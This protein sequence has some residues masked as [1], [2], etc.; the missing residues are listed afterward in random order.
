M[1]KK[2]LCL[3]FVLPLVFASIF[4]LSSC[5]CS[6]ER[7]SSITLS[8]SGQDVTP[9]GKNT[10]TVLKRN[11]P[12][13]VEVKIVPDKYTAEDL[14]WKC[15]PSNVA[16]I[17]SR[18]ALSAKSEGWADVSAQYKNSNGELVYY[19]IKVYVSETKLPSFSSSDVDLTYEGM[20]LLESESATK[21]VPNNM[22]DN[23]ECKYYEISTI[24][25]K[26]TVVETTEI[27]NAGE[28]VVECTRRST[29]TLICSLNVHVL[30]A[31]IPT[32]IDV[33]NVTSVY[34]DESFDKVFAN[35]DEV[36][37]ENGTLLFG[38][39]A[40]SDREIG[41][42]VFVTKATLTSG[43]G[44]YA[45]E[46]QVK[47]STEQDEKNYKFVYT[48]GT[49]TITPRKLAVKVL[50]KTI[51][52]GEE[53]DRIEYELYDNKEY[54]E[55]G[56][57]FDGLNKISSSLV[58]YAQ[59]ISSSSFVLK[60]GNKTVAKNA[61]NQYDVLWNEDVVAEYDL[62]ANFVC[63]GN[64]QV[65][66]SS[67]SKLKINPKDITVTPTSRSKIYGEKDEAEYYTGSYSSGV[68]DENEI[69]PFVF[70]S[71]NTTLN[72]GE[73]NMLA[74]VGTYYYSI[75]NTKNKNY[76]FTLTS[77]AKP[78]STGARI[79]YEVTPV[80]IVLQF[81]DVSDV[82]YIATE[83]VG[84][85]GD[86]YI[87]EKVEILVVSEELV[88]QN[89]DCSQVFTD[90]KLSLV[91]DDKMEFRF[92][93]DEV[94][95]S[96]KNSYK[97]FKL[98]M[99]EY[100]FSDANSKKENYRVTLRDSYI[101]TKRE[102]LTVT[103]NI[104]PY[105][106][107]GYTATR[108]YDGTNVTLDDEFYKS[109]TLKGNF[110]NGE[111]AQDVLPQ[112]TK[113]LTLQS[114][115]QYVKALPS[116]EILVGEMKD[117][118]KYKIMLD[119]TVTVN[120]GM[121]HYELVFD[122]S[123][124][125][126]FEITQKQVHV[127]LNSSTT[128]TIDGV[129]YPSISKIYGQDDPVFEFKV[130]EEIT[131]SG[132]GTLG[133]TRT[134]KDSEVVGN[135]TLSLGD[136]S[137]GENYSVVLDTCYLVILPREVLVTPTSPVV[138]YGSDIE[139]NQY[140]YE[141]SHSVP[142]DENLTNI[143][144]FAGM[145]IL[146]KDDENVTRKTCYKV[147]TYDIAQGTFDCT[148]SNYTL[149]F[150]SGSTYTVNAKKAVLDILPT[151]NADK[152][153]TPIQNATLGD[154]QLKLKQAVGDVT[155]AAT[156]ATF[157]DGVDNYYI[158]SKG[159]ITLSIILD[160]E[161]VTD[162]YEWALGRNVAYYFG[163]SVIEVKVV[164]KGED[165][166]TATTTYTGD[167]VADL[168]ELVCT[169][170]TYSISSKSNISFYYI[171]ELGQVLTSAPANAGSY[172]V[173]PK[174]DSDHKLVIEYILDGETK[175]V[176][177]SELPQTSNLFVARLQEE[178][179]LTIRKAE[180]TVATDKVK[181][182][183]TLTYGATTLPDIMLDYLDGVISKYVFSVTEKGVIKEAVLKEFDGKH[184]KVAE[185]V[186]E[187]A[188]L[189]VGQYT[190]TLIVQPESA[191]YNPATIYATL[192]IV[193]KEVKLTGGSA[194]IPEDLIYDGTTKNCVITPTFDL[195][196]VPYRLS[197]RYLRLKPES[198]VDGVD[199]K[200]KVYDYANGSVNLENSSLLDASAIS[201][202][203]NEVSYMTVVVDGT[204]YVVLNGTKAVE[205][206]SSN[207]SP[208]GA[209]VYLCVATISSDGNNYSITRNGG[210][211]EI[212]FLYEI[213]K[214]GN[215][216]FTFGNNEFF[217][218][219]NF[220]LIDQTRADFPFECSVSPNI[221][222]SLLFVATDGWGGNDILG[223]G[224]Y[225]VKV[226]AVT[227]N[228]YKDETF[229]F[230]V[231]PCVAE[232]EF[233]QINSYAYTGYKI[234][235]FFSNIKIKL[236]NHRGELSSTTTLAAAIA[237]ND[238]PCPI[239]TSFFMFNDAMGDYSISLAENKQVDLAGNEN[240]V[241]VLVG[242]YL[243]ALTVGGENAN[244]YGVSNYEYSISKPAN[245]GEI[246]VVTK[247]VTYNPNISPLGL[248]NIIRYGDESKLSTT[249]GMFR[250]DLTESQYTLNIYVNVNGT[251]IE[252]DPEATD[253][254]SWVKYVMTC[255][256][257]GVDLKFV[258]TFDPDLNFAPAEVT[259]K[260]AVAKRTISK[261]SFSEPS[262]VTGYYYNGREVYHSLK[263]RGF[264]SLDKLLS[265]D[266]PR[267]FVNG[268][269][270]VYVS[271]YDHMKIGTDYAYAVEI[272]D[273]LGNLI[274]LVGFM[275][276]DNGVKMDKCPIVPSETYR[277]KYYIS[278]NGD[279]YASADDINP[280]IPESS[281]ESTFRINKISL[282][283]QIERKTKEYSN[284]SFS[285]EDFKLEDKDL[286]ENN[287]KITVSSKDVT[288]LNV[289][290]LTSG[291]VPV[292][293]GSSNIVILVRL[294]LGSEVISIEKG[295][296]SVL[297]VGDYTVQVSLINSTSYDI[298]KFFN[299][300]TLFENGA[301]T[302][303]TAQE[304]KGSGGNDGMFTSCA[305]QLLTVKPVNFQYE[306]LEDMVKA[307]KTNRDN[308]DPE[309]VAYILQNGRKYFYSKDENK[310]MLENENGEGYT[311]ASDFVSNN[312]VKLDKFT[313]I[314]LS[315][316]YKDTYKLEFYK[317][318]PAWETTNDL[319]AY[320]SLQ[321]LI[322]SLK[323]NI[324]D[325][326][327]DANC[328]VKF[329][330]KNGN[331][332]S[333]NELRFFRIKLCPWKPEDNI[334]QDFELTEYNSGIRSAIW[335]ARNDTLLSGDDSDIQ[336]VEGGVA[337]N[338][339]VKRVKFYNVEGIRRFESDF[340]RVNRNNKDDSQS[341][342][343]FMLLFKCTTEE[344]IDESTGN[345]NTTITLS[346]AGYA[347]DEGSDI[348]GQFNKEI[349]V[350]GGNSSNVDYFIVI[351]TN[352]VDGNYAYYY[353][354]KIT[355]LNKTS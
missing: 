47:Y 201:S 48:K 6:E 323:D 52:Y 85:D 258:V 172:S 56:N 114:D 138:T 229:E 311:E 207:V 303:R 253:E 80:E 280:D 308:K 20:N 128:V 231:K 349:S 199:I 63:S 299:T 284:S 296:P 226:K 355:N 354:L 59:N 32:L 62:V 329:V 160:G 179:Y 173:L 266:T 127:T 177:F 174:V 92:R 19:A 150:V 252:L 151:S 126:F 120:A 86:G 129:P 189:N 206:E 110:I 4:M 175:I 271:Y 121:E 98:A 55:N 49:H 156:V 139:L 251:D 328:V 259:R 31:A 336:T 255:Q 306:T 27:V 279:N 260:L 148:S 244:Y 307:N 261:D 39:G 76:N 178:G 243:L 67:P 65:E 11:K 283:I 146:Q 248:Y 202:S 118:G 77:D 215:L 136:V 304:I 268:S 195:G 286:N 5:S 291:D 230:K 234:D 40:D 23:Y 278:I 57:S 15:S 281:W 250:I 60:I 104:K 334:T 235:S 181:F 285:I 167:E 81:K 331:F 324:N 3:L 300:V 338:Y 142:F 332:E 97:K 66:N 218:G 95:N 25:G 99:R 257:G 117:C 38:I 70:V 339:I 217:Y 290:M 21:L 333:S 22:S 321:A 205:L 326:V 53:I 37:F 170:D 241:P 188:T 287:I 137:L 240:V 105:F 210:S 277:V 176:E 24:N 72:L 158:E 209:G 220:N 211:C 351:G 221:G 196:N 115:G 344:S 88:A 107:T 68:V 263:Y 238:F 26:K 161:D 9:T 322:K 34:G 186:E 164:K 272:T 147:G 131:G 292:F 246:T 132:S 227:P 302:E 352:S 44:S 182:E 122:T 194:E 298:T 93:L 183:N 309:P 224:T 270:K 13:Q 301:A 111:T 190:Y 61:Y 125:Y 342:D 191:N 43:V 346:Y 36:D 143:P 133:R 345:V 330:A 102:K 17:T 140:S 155:L 134:G 264:A 123:R 103:P 14:T 319:T 64:V 320:S 247:E 16:T 347:D 317:R 341:V 225:Q 267:E 233:P 141:I 45:V 242:K 145:F 78:T 165:V 82:Y 74:P 262:G 18:G 265:H 94:A 295:S 10:W 42:C 325:G 58:S 1:K 162:C 8:L 289:I 46:T 106:E 113:L 256:N 340:Y 163:K 89:E 282:S 169:N 171:D 239:T 84:L 79:V 312:I 335:N 249:N 200:L 228:F 184:Y 353:N 315:D 204:T 180:I 193:A 288:D 96:D 30:P 313:T 185:G 144:T 348:G 198:S 41:K 237:D 327:T 197:Y 109:F 152:N 91:G 316:A 149:T 213:K 108:V 73:G 269:E 236:Y 305:S 293:N 100:T 187:I 337:T 50:N 51:S 2:L 29:Q 112:D 90:G 71:F 124:T 159:D 310:F 135:Y 254:N 212:A 203:A 28:Y 350:I 166:T 275:Y 274:G 314:E 12:Y 294:L 54:I 343:A 75:D 87:L 130:L 83:N 208:Q 192:S 273:K 297:A 119:G 216:T 214:N 168:F 7:L 153:S 219:T 116:G 69:V 101:T 276:S 318:N 157:K 222:D 33:P 223:V 154:S 35:G 245:T 232:I